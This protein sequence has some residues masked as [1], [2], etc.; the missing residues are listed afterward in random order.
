MVTWSS[1]TLM[2]GKASC[3]GS[4][5]LS[6]EGRKVRLRAIKKTSQIPKMIATHLM[7]RILCIRVLYYKLM[8]NYLK[9]SLHPQRTRVHLYINK[10]LINIPMA[11]V[12]VYLN[13]NRTT[14]AAFLFYK[15]VFQTEF[16]GDIARMGD[17]PPQ[18]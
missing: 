16:I 14:E 5:I 17:A 15:E 18:E 12:S 2:C 11:K 3:P 4:Q 6:C 9:I 10:S 7:I 8:I 13:F 1:S